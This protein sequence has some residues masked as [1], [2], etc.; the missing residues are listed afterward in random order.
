MEFIREFKKDFLVATL[1][2]ATILGYGFCS[3]ADAQTTQPV[4]T[5]PSKGAVL[6]VLNASQGTSAVTSPVFDWSAFTAVTATVKWSKADGAACDC[7]T[8]AGTCTYSWTYRI[9]GSTSKTGPFF[10]LSSIGL[11]IP[12]QNVAAEDGFTLTPE[13]IATP[14]AQFRA[15]AVSYKDNTN[16]NVPT[17]C[18]LNIT[19]TPIP[20]TYRN[21]SDGIQ[22]AGA[23]AAANSS[24]V[25]SGGLDY[26]VSSAGSNLYTVRTARVNTT[27]VQA[28]GFGSA[29]PALPATTPVA[30]NA[31]TLVYA[32]TENQ[33]GVRLQNVGANPALCAAGASAA[34]VAA[35]RYSFALA[36]AATA[37]A[38]GTFDVQQLD[39][40]SSSAN[41]KV[42][43]LGSGGATS[44][45][46][47]PY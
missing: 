37:G 2:V 8:G 45:A 14:Y 33:R 41:G 34:S 38:G 10:I 28:V 7:P 12:L 22:A 16:T 46:I 4:Y 5:R 43:C 15:E 20:F 40:S 39:T 44:I 17:A 31:A 6:T 11:N 26:V 3:D 18:F 42:Y 25:I 23:P 1:V 30:V 35:G 36:A 13:N 29:N 19:I 27:G 9:S 47:L 24:P 32:A 21:A